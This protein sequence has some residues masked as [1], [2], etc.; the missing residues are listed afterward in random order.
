V[1]TRADTGLMTPQQRAQI[2]QHL[3]QLGA[4]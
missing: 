3:P 1:A 4:Q 2:V